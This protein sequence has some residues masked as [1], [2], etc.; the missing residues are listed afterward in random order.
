MDVTIAG[1][2]GAGLRTS[3]QDALAWYAVVNGTS[4]TGLERLKATHVLM[5]G[6]GMRESSGKYCEGRDMSAENSKAD[7][8]EAGPFQTS[9]N[10]RS[11]ELDRLNGLWVWYKD[12]LEECD[13]DVWKQGVS[14]SHKSCKP[15]AVGGGGGQSWQEFTRACPAFA[16]DWAAVVLRKRRQHFGPIN[17]KEVQFVP[18]CK[19]LLDQVELLACT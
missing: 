14:P 4:S 13:L 16:A 2:I 1:V 3:S 15:D 19:S 12:N 7:T 17:R 8:A 6:L 5:F 11:V 18:A 10:S 9:Y